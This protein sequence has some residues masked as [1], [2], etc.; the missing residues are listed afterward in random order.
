MLTQACAQAAKHP[1]EAQMTACSRMQYRLHACPAQPG[2]ASCA[3]GH[4]LLNTYN[5]CGNATVVM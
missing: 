4:V 3:C 2:H 1:V 5:P